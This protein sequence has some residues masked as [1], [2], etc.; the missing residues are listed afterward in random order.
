MLLPSSRLQ[1]VLP[2]GAATSSRPQ[3]YTKIFLFK[4]H[5]DS[6][7]PPCPCWGCVPCVPPPPFRRERLWAGAR[8]RR[9]SWLGL[10]WPS[11]WPGSRSPA[12]PM[13]FPRQGTRQQVFKR[14]V[15]LF[16]LKNKKQNP[17][18]KHTKRFPDPLGN[19]KY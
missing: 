1:P 2:T 15:G 18:D 11:S 12:W 14:S 19:S 13:L 8:L 16:F 10:R 5:G 4:I 3:C 17:N 7:T 6:N 9:R